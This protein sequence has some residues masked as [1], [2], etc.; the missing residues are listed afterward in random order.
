MERQD[1]RSV[2]E[3]NLIGGSAKRNKNTKIHRLGIKGR[4][5]TCITHNQTMS[6]LHQTISGLYQTTRSL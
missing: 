5:K 3:G 6:S 1:G 2:E 4:Y